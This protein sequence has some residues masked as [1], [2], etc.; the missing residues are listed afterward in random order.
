V[1]ALVLVFLVAFSGRDLGSMRAAESGPSA[2]QPA[3]QGD[4]A[5][6]ADNELMPDADTSTGS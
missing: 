4:L 3:R 2:G 6:A 1:L 5:S